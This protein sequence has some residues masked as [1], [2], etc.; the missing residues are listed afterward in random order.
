[1]YTGVL[2]NSTPNFLINKSTMR[3]LLIIGLLV[4][5]VLSQAKLNKL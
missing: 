1:M 5:L 3:I 2:F 4:L